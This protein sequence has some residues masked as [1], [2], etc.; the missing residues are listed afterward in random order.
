M[1]APWGS[2]DW[3]KGIR[4]DDKRKHALITNVGVFR[5]CSQ[6][7]T[8]VNYAILDSSN[9]KRGWVSYDSKA[10]ED[11]HTVRCVVVGRERDKTEYGLNS[12]EYCILVVRPTSV[13]GEYTRVGIGWIQSGYVTRQRLHVRVV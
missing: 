7:K 2:M 4:F 5:N 3:N 10:G 1:N 9:T 11:F 13:D 12:K 6:K 8:D